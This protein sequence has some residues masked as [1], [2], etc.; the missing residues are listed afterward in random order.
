MAAS[1][2][3]AAGGVPPLPPPPE[4]VTE[5]PILGALPFSTVLPVESE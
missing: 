1:P 4:E 5:A 3:G 2:V